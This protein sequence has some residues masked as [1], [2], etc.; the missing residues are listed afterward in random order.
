MPESSTAT[1]PNST[2]QSSP[3]EPFLGNIPLVDTM[4][5]L[6]LETA[7]G[8]LRIKAALHAIHLQDHQSLLARDQESVSQ[9]RN[10]SLGIE[11]K[12]ATANQ[13]QEDDMGNIKIGDT[14]NV[15]HPAPVM[16]APAAAIASAA[17]V[18]AGMSPWMKAGAILGAGALAGGIPGAAIAALG[19]FNQPSVVAP[20]EPPTFTAPEWEMEVVPN[21]PSP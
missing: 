10:K 6:A 1:P 15:T 9:W 13:A 18:A 4:P 3:V 5:E 2:N 8:A 21:T 17:P 19:Y 14:Y 16:S 20:A 11:D 7:R 12:P